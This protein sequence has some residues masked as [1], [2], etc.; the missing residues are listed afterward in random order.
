LAESKSYRA[1][2]WSHAG[3]ETRR[4]WNSYRI[5]TAIAAPVVT[6]LFWVAIRGWTDWLAILYA[7]L[8]GILIFLSGWGIVFIVSCGLAPV[9]LDAQSQHT[10]AELS[11]KLELPDKALAVHLTQLL[12]NV[13]PH[14]KNLIKFMLLYDEE[15]G[16]AQVSGGLS[17]KDLSKTLRECSDQGLIKSRHEQSGP[18]GM[19]ISSFYW[20]PDGFRPTL[21]RILYTQDQAS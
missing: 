3:A 6:A 1:R 18:H 11:K 9:A 19:F 15:V 10:I 8:L 13:G 20:I 7:L 21:K 12:E 5:S 4:F 2:L 16:R 14:G 17:D